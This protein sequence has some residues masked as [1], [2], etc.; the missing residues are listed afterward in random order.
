MASLV[1]QE[2]GD[3]KNNGTTNTLSPGIINNA[4]KAQV[5]KT[6]SDSY[7]NSS[8]PVGTITPS[9]TP[10]QA[11][12]PQG[13]RGKAVSSN[14]VND[15]G[16]SQLPPA[17]VSQR[18]SQLANNNNDNEKEEGVDND[19]DD[20]EEADAVPRGAQALISNL[21]EMDMEVADAL[22]SYENERKALEAKYNDK[23]RI[24][25]NQRLNV[26]HGRD[27]NTELK[28]SKVDAQKLEYEG[29]VHKSQVLPGFWRVA[30]ENSSLLREAIAKHDI[31]CLNY[32]VDIQHRLLPSVDGGDA[33]N[34]DED[35]TQK[36]GFALDFLFDSANNPYFSNSILTKEYLILSMYDS[37]I[38]EP[39]LK[40]I[41]GTRINWYD[42]K[43]L[44]HKLVKQRKKGTS[45]TRM[46]LKPRV[47]F[48]NFFD[49]PT[50]EDIEDEEEYNDRC[51][52]FDL[53]LEMA[54]IIREKTI[55]RA[56]RHYTGEENSDDEDE[57]D[58]DDE[59]YIPG[60]NNEY[61]DDDDD[62]DDLDDLD[63]EL[64]NLGVEGV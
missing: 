9:N 15:N 58:D 52:I 29:I 45:E 8:P 64:A 24:L 38:S 61:D 13:H 47:S 2:T 54:L 40:T 27:G 10:Q 1:A 42:G 5:N 43:D 14:A 60:F 16:M 33:I 12:T 19:A 36:V 30:M 50:M 35:G 34:M 37:T 21:Q 41:N 51:D 49:A 53:D 22:A 44:T 23:L 57:D 6:R 11:M 56:I 46:V 28:P 62:D 48:F 18:L 7:N 59:D 63:E 39:T 31:E 25:Y 4:E 55:P 17:L 26:L 3:D 32:L 20:E